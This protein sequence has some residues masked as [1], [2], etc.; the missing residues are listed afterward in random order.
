MTEKRSVLTDE[1]LKQIGQVFKG[2]CAFTEE[3]VFALKSIVPVI[4]E[5]G[6]GSIY[7]GGV[8]FRKHTEF[9][10]RVVS[11]KNLVIGLVVVATIGA[12]VTNI[13]DAIRGWLG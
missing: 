13:I 12:L 2:H 4:K 1:D 11:K 9:V 10:T 7:E 8:L 3:D 6:N 5:L